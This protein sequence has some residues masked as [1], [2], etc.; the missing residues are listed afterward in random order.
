MKDTDSPARLLARDLLREALR[1][2][3]RTPSTGTPRANVAQSVKGAPRTT[4][5]R[6]PGRNGRPEIWTRATILAAIR[7]YNTRTG[8]VPADP[9]FRR[10]TAHRH[11]ARR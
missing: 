10:A 11:P 6:H 2:T 8:R 4:S 9:E 5:Q 3:A 1:E 7:A